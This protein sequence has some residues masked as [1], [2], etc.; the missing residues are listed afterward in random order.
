MIN[1]L[2][3]YNIALQFLWRFDNLHQ[4]ITLQWRQNERDDVSNQCRLGC[5]LN[6]FVQ[7]LIKET[8]KLRIT[9]LCEKNSPG[10]GE[11]PAQMTS[12]AENVPF[13]DVIMRW[14]LKSFNIAL[15]IVRPSRKT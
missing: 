10:T 9:G 11:F 3:V 1:Q 13:D 15:D 12:N 8:S 4:T 14:T 2:Y 5:L 7:A 6:R